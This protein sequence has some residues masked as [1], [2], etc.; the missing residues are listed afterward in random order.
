MEEES[1][2]C[3]STIT[4]KGRISLSWV[5]LYCHQSRSVDSCFLALIKSIITAQN[6]HNFNCIRAKLQNISF[7]QPF[8][9]DVLYRHKL[10]HHTKRS[11]P[12][13]PCSQCEKKYSSKCQLNHHIKSAHVL[14]PSP[15]EICGKIFDN[16]TKLTAHFKT[17]HSAKKPE[18]KPKRKNKSDWTC[19]ICSKVVIA[20][21][22]W[23]HLQVHK[24]PKFT[25]D[26]CGKKIRTKNNFD[27][28]MNIHMNILDYKCEPCNKVA[29]ANF[30]NFW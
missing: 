15:C 12:E 24:E 2:D 5:R 30:V 6:M 3:S 7:C 29:Y 10:K 14:E 26:I 19:P 17:M 22:K 4:P 13:F 25:C 27:Q 18:R 11:K 8:F 1:F 21:N 20:D 23:S 28:H 9:W 16:P